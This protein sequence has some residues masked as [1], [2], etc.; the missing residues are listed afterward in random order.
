MA[1]KTEESV[2]TN[3]TLRSLLILFF[4]SAWL[5]MLL[6]GWILPRIGGPESAGA[7][8][9]DSIRSS[10]G[11][12]QRWDMFSTIPTLRGYKMEIAAES[13]DGS[14]K[15]YGPVLPNLET[16]DSIGRT[17]Y[18]YAFTRILLGNQKFLDAYVA[19]MGGALK[20]KESGV[21]SFSIQLLTQRIRTLEL[22][23]QDGKLWKTDPEQLG[24]YPVNHD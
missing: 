23:R 8:T 5:L 19:Q 7:K 3:G 17:R 11:T 18:H 15:T 22:S 12:W 20:A 21:K 6:A 14:K 24:P 13:G 16:F 4:C 9:I 1:E 10:T 2:T